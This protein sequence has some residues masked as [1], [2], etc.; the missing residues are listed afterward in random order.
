[1]C[2]ITPPN[3]HCSQNLIYTHC[4]LR[5]L[6]KEN[7]TTR[8]MAKRARKESTGEED[9]VHALPPSMNG[10]QPLQTSYSYHSNVPDILLDSK[11]IMGVDE[12]GRGPVLGVLNLQL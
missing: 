2:L 4:P 9:Q 6:N 11:V 7:A 10:D 5:T 1:M 8:N 12:A 3:S